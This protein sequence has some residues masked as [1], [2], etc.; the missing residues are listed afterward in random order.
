MLKQIP[1]IKGVIL[2]RGVPGVIDR[3]KKPLENVLLAGCD[4]RADICAEPLW[5]AGDLQEPVENTYRVF[6]AE[7]PQDE[8]FRAAILCKESFAMWWMGSAVPEHWG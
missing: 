2:S 8:N 1:E 3:G 5:G 7:R 4:M 6:Q